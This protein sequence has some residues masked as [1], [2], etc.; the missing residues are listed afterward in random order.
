MTSSFLISKNFLYSFLLLAILGVILIPLISILFIAFGVIEIGVNSQASASSDLLNSAVFARYSFNTFVLLISVAV[1][2]TILGVSTAWLITFFQF[3][4]RGWFE[5]ILFLPL[6]M[7]SYVAAY[8]LVDFLEFAGPVQSTIR[9]TFGFNL[10]SEY[11]FPEIRSLGGA[12]IVLSL[13][14]FPYVYMFTRVA[15]REQS[16]TFE[17]V[18]R[19]LGKGTFKRF[20]HVVLP[21]IRPGIFG[22]LII[23]MMETIADYGVVDYFAIQTLTTGIYNVWL[24]GNDL[25]GSAQLAMGLVL[26]ILFI[27]TCERLL[28]GKAGFYSNQSKSNYVLRKPLSKGFQTLAIIYCTIIM[29]IGFVLPAGVILEHALGNY[30]EWIKPELVN[31]LKNSLFTALI[32]SIVTLFM[33]IIIVF[34]KPTFEKSFFRYLIPLTTLGYAVPGAVI[35]L[36]ILIF[37]ISI[38]HTLAELINLLFNIEPSLLL[39]GTSIGIVLAYCIRFFAISY[40]TIE[41]AAGRINPSLNFVPRLLGKTASQSFV[42]VHFPLIKGSILTGGL[43]VFVDSIKELPATLLLRPFNYN[44]LATSVYEKASLE[45]IGQASPAALLIIFTGCC[46]VFLIIQMDKKANYNPN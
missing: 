43:L 9:Q 1:L 19:T 2:S 10:A 42:K 11:F 33:A 23:V 31:A 12:S 4:L 34:G 22:G 45:N 7:P 26:F 36:G 32:A 17:E 3:P 30:Q 35:G 20:F 25:K 13:V 16:S 21:I 37:L 38:D 28:K 44:T 41:T 39:T 18:A 40:N 46:G 6:A 27:V 15:L 8:A 29:A 14:L 24:E 5:V